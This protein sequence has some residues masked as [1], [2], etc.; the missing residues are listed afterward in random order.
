MFICKIIFGMQS[1]IIQSS[2]ITVVPFH[3]FQIFI[4]FLQMAV[5]FLKVQNELSELKRQKCELEEKLKL[6]DLNVAKSERELKEK[7]LQLQAE[8]VFYI[9][10]FLSLLCVFDLI[11]S[12]LLT[13]LPD[14]NYKY[15]L[16]LPY[17]HLIR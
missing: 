15:L 7:V 17:H 16:I 10:L 3:T 4:F 14:K 13:R 12:C 2:S 9:N 5:D 6:L 8:K 11:K 1:K